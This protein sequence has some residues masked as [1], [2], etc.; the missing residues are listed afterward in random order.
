MN[1][2]KP[3]LTVKNLTV[4]LSTFRG[5]AKVVNDLSLEIYEGEIFGLVGESGCGKTMTALSIIRLLPPNT[6]I[7]SGSILLNGEDLLS[8]PESQMAHVRGKQIAM[9]FQDPATS[10][11]PVIK[12][13]DHLVETIMSLNGVTK[14]EAR[15]EAIDLLHEVGI[16]EPELRFNQYPF[17]LSG[18]LK[19]RVM[20]ALALAGRPKLLIADEPTTN[21]DVT[22]QWQILNLLKEIRDRRDMS[23]LLITH[24]LGIVATICDRAAVMY[25]GR[26]VELG[27]IFSIFQNPLHPYTRLLIGCV[28]QVRTRVNRLPVINGELH[29]LFESPSGCNFHTRCPLARELCKNI[30]PKLLSHANNH[31][32]K[33]LAYEQQY[34]GEWMR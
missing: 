25:A 28:P 34:R 2:R 10:L 6:Q 31:S 33:C 5:V 1:G 11:N 20:I 14:A 21:L 22:V 29:D 9:I 26:I 13:G 24:N 32:V 23:V 15:R 18:G 17:Q 12:V 7:W 8:K 4:H 16:T 27:D 30:E 19:Q 3:L